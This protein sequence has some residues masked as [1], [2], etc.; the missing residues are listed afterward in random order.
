MRKILVL[1]VIMMFCVV[2]SSMAEEF[3]NKTRP[4]YVKVVKFDQAASDTNQVTLFA[5]SSGNTVELSKIVIRCYNKSVDAEICVQKGGPQSTA[6]ANLSN[7]LAYEV[8]TYDSSGVVPLYN[9]EIPYYALSP[10]SFSD[11]DS[12]TIFCRAEDSSDTTANTSEATDIE[13]TAYIYYRYK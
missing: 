13:G 1:T 6:A 10:A 12:V 5:G 2:V 11:G 4:E 3:N 9:F 7:R 8:V